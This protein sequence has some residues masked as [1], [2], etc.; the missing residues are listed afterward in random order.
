MGMEVELEFFSGLAGAAVCFELIGVIEPAEDY[1]VKAE[2]TVAVDLT[3][4]FALSKTYEVEFTIEE[5]VKAEH[6][7]PGRILP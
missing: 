1:R 7:D 3:V 6:F 5:H 4:A 2:G